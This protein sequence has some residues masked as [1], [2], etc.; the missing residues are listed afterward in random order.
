MSNALNEFE[1]GPYFWLFF[2]IAFPLLFA[3]IWSAIHLLLSYVTG[4]RKLGKLYPYAGEQAIEWKH[5]GGGGI[6]RANLPFAGARGRL[7]VGATKTG[8]IIKPS[9]FARPFS[10]RL[11]LPF[12]QIESEEPMTML[13][14]DFVIMTM[15]DAPD[16][17]VGIL[18]SAREMAENVR[19]VA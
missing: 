19:N 3:L 12:D 18:K 8:I 17:R 7:G 10:P 11:F 14:L 6:Y 16:I 1:N 5:R 13:T 2:V 9:I 4:W 15:K